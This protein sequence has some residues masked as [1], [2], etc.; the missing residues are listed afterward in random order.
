MERP[1]RASDDVDWER[2]SIA[3]VYDYYLGGSHNF[4]VDRRMARR[5]IEVWPELPVI[6]QANRAFLRRAVRYLIRAGITQ[7]LD[8]GSG[9]PTEG[10][11][12]EVAQM[13]LPEARV[14]YVDIDPIAVAYS[15]DIL[16]GNQRVEVIQADLRDV[17]AI[18]DDSRTRRLIN[19]TQ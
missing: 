6:M 14:V 10:N 18:F 11:V 2:P 8:L 12:H 19:P 17:A 9:I 5:A 3:R 15:R 4:V 16:S 7:F 1:G 13:A